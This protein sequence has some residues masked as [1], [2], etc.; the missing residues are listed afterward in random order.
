MGLMTI[1]SWPVWGAT[2]TRFYIL[3]R[4]GV[5]AGDLLMLMG[6]ALNDADNG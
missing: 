6:V 2:T 3:A 5:S 4:P 1:M